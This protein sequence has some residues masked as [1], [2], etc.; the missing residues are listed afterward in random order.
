MTEMVG[1]IQRD[2]EAAAAAYFAWIGSNP[3]IPRKMRAG[4][5]DSHSM[6][7]AFA[8]HRIAALSPHKES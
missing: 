6:V 5:A 1:A 4:E 8:R 2:R 7:Q 3:V